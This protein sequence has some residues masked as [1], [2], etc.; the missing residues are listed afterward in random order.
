MAARLTAAAGFLAL[1]VVVSGCGIAASTGA[2]PPSGE[3]SRP[4]PTI[5]VGVAAARAE[6]A[7]ALGRSNLQLDNAEVPFRPAES[8][9]LAA[10]PRA[11]FQAV[12]PGA[13][14]HGFITVYEMGTE[15]AATAAG[16]EQWEYINSG[17][18]RV[19]FRPDTQFVLRRLGSTLVFYAFGRESATEEAIEVAAAL[20]EVGEAVQ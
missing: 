9:T 20:N 15:E 5:T 1:A 16:S 4:A 18:G 14:G 11:V 12:L 10:A 6:I 3:P 2:A 17:P 7:T 8:P 19:Q 13:S